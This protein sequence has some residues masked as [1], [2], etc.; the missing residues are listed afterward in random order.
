MNKGHSTIITF[1]GFNL[2]AFGRNGHSWA[3][4][5]DIFR[6]ASDGVSRPG[7]KSVPYVELKSINSKNMP[8]KGFLQLPQDPATLREMAEVLN[9]IADAI[10]TE[11]KEVS[12]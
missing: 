5:I 8:T 11:S 6:S 12:P 1:P 9:D 7:A 3:D 2:R 4:G 10:E